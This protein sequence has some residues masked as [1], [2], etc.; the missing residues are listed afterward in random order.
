M[1]CFF[2]GPATEALPPTLELG[3]HIFLEFFFE[4]QKKFFFL[5][6]KLP[7]LVAGP[8]KKLFLRLPLANAH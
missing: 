4:L 2:S 3:D 5:V 8:Q 6:A 1:L 7:I